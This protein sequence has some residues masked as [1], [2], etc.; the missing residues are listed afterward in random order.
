MEKNEQEFNNLT[1]PWRVFSFAVGI[2]ILNYTTYEAINQVM[3]QSQVVFHNELPLFAG[4]YA[5]LVGVTGWFDDLP[6]RLKRNERVTKSM[7]RGF[8]LIIVCL[9]AGVYCLSYIDQWIESKGYQ[10]VSEEGRVR[11]RRWEP[12]VYIKTLPSRQVNKSKKPP[13][14]ETPKP[15]PAKIIS[16]YD[17]KI[18][19]PPTLDKVQALMRTNKSLGV[20]FI[21]VS[22]TEIKKYCAEGNKFPKV[23]LVGCE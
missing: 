14:E 15:T 18:E 17:G 1:W 7:L 10:I 11:S 8:A 2:I 20:E 5:I 3:D 6:Y 21:N 16:V 13:L 23:M 19:G 4:V 12:S 22:P 9:F